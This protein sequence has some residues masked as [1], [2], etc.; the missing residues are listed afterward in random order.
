[1]PKLKI[2]D[3][4]SSRE[5]AVRHFYASFLGATLEGESVP[6]FDKW[7]SAATPEARTIASKHAHRLAS[8]MRAGENFGDALRD[9]VATC[10][11]DIAS[12]LP[13]SRDQDLLD[14]TKALIDQLMRALD[15]MSRT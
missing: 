4:P 10:R 11:R 15:A 12:I 1:M 2:S 6:G 3:L 5:D 13:P 9:E 8:R 14:Q 7:W